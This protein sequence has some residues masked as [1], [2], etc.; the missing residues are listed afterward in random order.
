M[1]SKKKNSDQDREA[2]NFDAFLAD[3]AP[4]TSRKSL[5]SKH[6]KQGSSKA[7]SDSNMEKTVPVRRKVTF[8]SILLRTIIPVSGALLFGYFIGA[9]L[10]TGTKAPQPV[11]QHVDMVTGRSSMLNSLADM[12]DSEIDSLQQQLSSLQPA[13]SASQPSDAVNTKLTMTARTNTTVSQTLDP[14]FETLL[15]MK[16]KPQKT[17]LQATADNLSQY[18]SVSNVQNVD[19]TLQ[20]QVLAKN[21]MTFLKGDSAAKD[22]KIT[23]AKGAP[24]FASIV[25]MTMDTATYIVYAQFANT[26]DTV[27]SVYSVTI[28][29]DQKISGVSYVGYIKSTNAGSFFQSSLKNMS[30][31]ADENDKQLQ[32]QKDGLTMN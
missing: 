29:N 25:S 12:K 17:D 7:E 3:E 8:K 32:K 11:A 10:N 21:L 14:F 4:H 5:S 23:G 16:Y 28:G 31:S 20:K 22:L 27:T 19:S 6:S 15:A 18:M 26:K 30:E 2:D 1:S 24:V 13:T 9:L